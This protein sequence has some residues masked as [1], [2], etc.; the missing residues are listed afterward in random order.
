MNKYI[1][2]AIIAVT[3]ANCTSNPPA[4]EPKK[5]TLQATQPTATNDPLSDTTKVKQWIA[6]VIEDFTNSEHSNA[7]HDSMVNSLTKDYYEYKQ[8]ALNLEY[9]DSTMTEEGFKKKWQHKYNT[10]LVGEGGYLI[11]AQ[12]NG[13][14]KVTTCNWM[15]NTDNASF[16]KVVIEDLDFKTL[17]HRDIK[18]IYQNGK[19][20]IDDILEYD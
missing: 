13:K 4:G 12:D 16:Y 8:E 7:A 19:F 1:I 18:V 14:I 15:R 9:D 20:L 5:D 11:S 3:L 17:F 10:G 6:K 2:S